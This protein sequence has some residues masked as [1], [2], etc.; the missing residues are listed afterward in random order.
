M[1][2]IHTILLPHDLLFLPVL[3]SLSSDIFLLCSYLLFLVHSIKGTA[4]HFLRFLFK[5]SKFFFY[6]RTSITLSSLL[7]TSFFSGIDLQTLLFLYLN[8]CYSISFGLTICLPFSLL[9]FVFYRL[10]YA[11]NRYVAT[12]RLIFT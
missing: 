10:I 6:S 8:T 11:S 3:T 2:G 4:L 12:F 7:Q 5:F 9:L 1:C